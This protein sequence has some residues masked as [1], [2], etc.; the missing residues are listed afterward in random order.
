VIERDASS[1]FLAAS[2][3]FPLVFFTISKSKLPGYILPAIPPASFLMA[4][5]LSAG[6]RSTARW[7]PL[8]LSFFALTPVAIIATMSILI[9]HF[10]REHALHLV[11]ASGAAAFLG[12]NACLVCAFSR[13][14]H[15][16]V[17]SGILTLVL[18]VEIFERTALPW[19]DPFESPRSVAVLVRGKPQIAQQVQTFRL[20]RGAQY[21]LNFYLHR[22]LVEWDGNRDGPVFAF[23]SPGGINQLKVR[24]IP[25]TIVDSTCLDAFLVQ[26]GR[27][28]ATGGIVGNISA[29]ENR[30][31]DSLTDRREA[32]RLKVGV[33]SGPL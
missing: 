20:R 3:V 2:I 1:F 16:L 12:L 11:A 17:V 14:W 15:A 23:A 19:F 18:G 9:F 33:T 28:E 32:R 6:L 5:Y 30:F 22:E 13:R 24:K 8:G 10:F 26:I 7:K 25:Y 21:A 4:G 27:P 29:P 31:L